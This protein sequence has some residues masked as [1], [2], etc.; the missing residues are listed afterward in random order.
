MTNTNVEEYKTINIY[1]N[2]LTLKRRIAKKTWTRLMTILKICKKLVA[3]WTN[4]I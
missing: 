1:M 4:I 2:A 3:Y